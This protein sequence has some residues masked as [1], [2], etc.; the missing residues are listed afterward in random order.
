MIS[1]ERL[2]TAARAVSQAMIDSLPEPE[3]CHHDFSPEFERKMK[4]LLRR[5]RHWGLYQGLK[6]AACFFLVLLLSGGAFLTVNAEAREIVF[7]WVSQQLENTRHYFF[8]E[9]SAGEVSQ[10]PSQEIDYELPNVP[11][12]YRL[13][14]TDKGATYTSILYVNEEGNYLSFGYLTKETETAT[15]N[16]VFGTEG[17]E[18]T[19]V[20][21]HSAP[22]DYYFDDTGEHSNLIVWKDEENEVLLYITG[23]L[24]K[25]GLIALA[26]SVVQKEN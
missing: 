6:R 2:R 10:E 21:V 23:Y 18:K 9:E 15:S 12:E 14:D 19:T 26:E 13:E 8:V 11:E 3:D 5:S 7:G 24:D 17:F 16:I 25:D 1:E 22:A 4:K 20:L